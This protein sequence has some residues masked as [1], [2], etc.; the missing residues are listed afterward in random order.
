M[1]SYPC[2]QQESLNYVDWCVE[3]H[4][5]T[6]SITGSCRES[7]I[8]VDFLNKYP[9]TFTVYVVH[10]LLVGRVNIFLL[11]KNI[12]ALMWRKWWN[13]FLGLQLVTY[14]IMEYYTI[15]KDNIFPKCNVCTCLLLPPQIS[16]IK[17]PGDLRGFLL[18]LRIS[19]PWDYFVHIFDFFVLILTQRF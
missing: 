6:N 3:R 15:Y 4:R 1:W 5:S 9:L 18:S 8:P 14:E 16:K 12:C 19:K 13:Q 7:E 11:K 10:M 17:V 2:N